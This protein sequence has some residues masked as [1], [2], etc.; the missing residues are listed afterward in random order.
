M[1]DDVRMDGC[2]LS[3]FFQIATPPTIFCPILTQ[4]GTHD[5]SI[6]KN[7]GTDFRNLALKIFG[8]F[9]K[10]LCQQRRSLG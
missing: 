2:M 6:Q 10:F 5:V 3:N 8:K 9:L 4:I 7:C 1:G